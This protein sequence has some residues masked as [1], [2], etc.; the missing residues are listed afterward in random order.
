MSEF[1]RDF[2]KGGCEMMDSLL[3]G[4]GG[5]DVKVLKCFFVIEVLV[6]FDEVGKKEVV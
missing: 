2:Y 5:D 6:N 4:F 1:Q 3:Y